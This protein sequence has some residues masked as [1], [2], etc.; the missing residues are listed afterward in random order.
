MLPDYPIKSKTEDLLGR[1][2]LAEKVASLILE[3]QGDESFVIGI[4]GAWGSGKTSFVNLILEQL[5]GA[6]NTA[7]IMEFNPWSFSGPSELI[8]DFFDSLIA[9]TKKDESGKQKIKAYAAKLIKKSEFAFEPE[10]SFLGFKVSAGKIR[11]FGGGKTLQESRKVVDDLLRDAGKRIVIVVDDTDRLDVQETKLIFKLLK[12]T[13]NFPN[14]IFILA[15][16]REKVAEKVTEKG[17]PGEEY[18][19]KIIQVNFRLPQPDKQDLHRILFHDIDLSIKNMDESKWNATRW[20][21]LFRE[22]LN[23][24][25]KTL[26]DVKRYVSSLRLDLSIIGKD[27]VNSVDLLGIEAIR[28]FAPNIYTVIGDNKSLFTETRSLYFG[29]TENERTTQ[30]KEI[31]RIIESYEDS[32]LRGSLRGIIKELFPQVDGLYRNTNYGPDWQVEWRKNLQVASPDIFGRYFQLST[33]VG[34][35]SEGAMKILMSTLTQVKAF[36]DNLR[37]INQEGKLRNTLTR[38]MDYLGQLEENQKQNLITELMSFGDTVKG[39]RVGVF[40]LEDADTLIERLI[41]HTIKSLSQDK[42]VDFLKKVLEETSF[43]F[44]GT[45]MVGY[46]SHEAIEYEEKKSTQEPLLTKTDLD[47]LQRLC[48]EQFK[49]AENQGILLTS[50]NLPHILFRWKEWGHEDDAKAFI[51][52]NIES[53]KGLVALLVT[54]VS[55]IFSTTGDYNTLNKKTLGE[56]YDIQE[57]ERKVA[58]ISNQDLQAMSAEEKEA[59]DL[60]RKPPRNLFG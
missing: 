40:D 20:S 38:A 8:E 51:K 30:L 46:L 22:G 27:E 32:N 34:T 57:I 13:A 24:F 39:E 43:T 25:F 23:G 54:F 42:R 26:R 48:V 2:P 45:Y 3:F 6:D 58:S 15:Y 14:T 18:L 21:S 11:K 19:K 29:S 10:V 17:L 47:I 41:Y 59:V 35:M 52:R 9:A 49:A 33:P 53:Q 55:R 4:D 1:A 16:D 44:T 37:K 7:L 56:L 31:D 28:V 36:T 60:F 5:R 50:K 12:M